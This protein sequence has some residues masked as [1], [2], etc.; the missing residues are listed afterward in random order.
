MYLVFGVVCWYYLFT[1]L[2]SV[3]QMPID[4]RRLGLG[5]FG[6]VVTIGWK[7]LSPSDFFE[8]IGFLEIIPGLKMIKVRKLLRIY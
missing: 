6:L 7:L 8:T 5:N 1:K 3:H 4:T 2:P